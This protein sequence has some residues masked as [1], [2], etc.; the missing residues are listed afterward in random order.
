MADSPP[1]LHVTGLAAGGEGIARDPGGRVVLVDGALPG[2]RVTATPLRARRGRP[3]AVVDAVLEA[4]PERVAPPCPFVT[5]GCGGCGWQHVDPGG[6]RSLKAAL[7]ADALRYAGVE[8]P[9]VD[10]GPAL[11]AVDYRTTV[12]GVV[13][14]EGRV[15]LRRPR[16]HDLVPV[17]G[18]L[19]AHPLVVEVLAEGR[20]PPGAEVTVRAGARTGE[21]LVILD[22]PVDP[23][24]PDDPAP[25]VRG[26][27]AVPD[28]VRVVE[29]AD[30]AA[31]KRAWIHE[32][33]AGRRLRVSARSFF[34]S[35][36]AGAEALVE[37][38]G[39][40]VGDAAGPGG[41]VLDLY[42]GVGLFAATVAAEAGGRVTL[43]DAS[44][45]GAADARVNLR[46]V[47]GLDARVVRSDV[48][49]WHPR[50]AHVVIADPPRA[51]LGRGPV[52]VVGRTG[53]ER[54]VLVSCDAAAL[55]RD[56]RLL[57]RAGYR[58]VGATLVD[59]FV[60]TPHV[61]VVSR[62]DRA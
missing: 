26:D 40:A 6:Q 4:A 10:E 33:V 50:R 45:G 61:E 55:G 21:R 41:H 38:V 31:G 47:E 53:A 43:V 27:V 18:C 24:T 9:E 37:A 19:V 28:G 22:R 62:F 30:L 13:D 56:A 7:V 60:G 12:R 35:G 44:A 1:A 39:D 14:A 5:A 42:G 57:A 54:V 17:P 52:A 11:P 23:L 51:G 25:V 36:P 20:F 46:A 8:D 3:H 49:R 59:Q 15:A 34:Q 32:E 2:E 48:A 58:F 29:G 16:S